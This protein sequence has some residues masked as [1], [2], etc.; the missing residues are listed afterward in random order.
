MKTLKI[1]EK[2]FVKKFMEATLRL[3]KQI[4]A[5]KMIYGDGYIKYNDRKIEVILPTRVTIIHTKKGK[6]TGYKVEE[7]PQ[8]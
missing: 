6:I 2:D 4:G 3:W 5:D 8:K 7:N 1:N